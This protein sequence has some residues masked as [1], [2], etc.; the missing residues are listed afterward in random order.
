[1]LNQKNHATNLLGFF[2][3]KVLV[4]IG[5]VLQDGFRKHRQKCISLSR[6][7]Q[8]AIF[9]VPSPVDLAEAVRQV[10]IGGDYSHPCHVH[11]ISSCARFSGSLVQVCSERLGGH[12]EY[13]IPFAKCIPRAVSFPYRKVGTNVSSL[14]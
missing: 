11:C 9:L 1:M 2:C 6:S 7:T 4:I 5:A 10:L 8:L 12:I 3:F 14:F 13:I